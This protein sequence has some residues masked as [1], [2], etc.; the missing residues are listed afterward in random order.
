MPVRAS[1]TNST[2]SASATA[3]AAPARM[4]PA[5]VSGAASSSPAVSI[6]L[7]VRPRSSASASF[8]SRVTPG[9][10]ATRA[11]RR[12]ARR[13]N[14]VDFPT[15]GRPAIT[16]TGS[17]IPSDDVPRPDTL[18]RS[19]G[20]GPRW[21]ASTALSRPPGVLPAPP[22]SAP[23]SLTQGQQPAIVADHQQRAVDH[24]RR[25]RRRGGGQRLTPEDIPG[26]RTDG[27]RILIG[28]GDNQA[29]ADQHRA[30]PGQQALL[31]FRVVVAGQRCDPGNAS[32]GEADRRHFL[33]QGD[34]EQP[35]AGDIG[36]VLA[37]N[38]PLPQPPAR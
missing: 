34:Q 15:L 3:D 18:S 9:V 14:S 4:R 8:R 21:A 1:M 36:R 32:I 6:S 22:R 24:D 19:Y 23:G 25:D 31:L 35:S 38:L 13:L 7:T 28:A 5:R 10:S 33:L 12:P 29:V 16:T 11:S 17:M 2:R 26:V 27:E 30:V 20:P 37:G